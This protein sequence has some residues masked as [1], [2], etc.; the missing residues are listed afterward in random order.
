MWSLDHL[1]VSVPS[2]GLYKTKPP[3]PRVIKTLIQVPRQGQE[4]RTKNKKTIVVGENEILTREIQ[5]HMKPWVDIIRENA[6][7]LGGHRDHVSACLCHMLYCIETST[8]YNLAFFIL[9][10]MEK[11]RF[12]LKELL[13]YGM[14]LTSSSSTTQNH[15]SSSHLLDHIVDENDD[16]S[17]HSNSS[18]PSQQV[19]SLS[20]VASRV[21]QNPSHESHELNI[22]LSK[23]ITLQTQQQNAHQDGLRLIG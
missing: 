3:S 8:P 18:S 1:S 10:R 21:R 5:T 23:T 12:K 22:F 16:E 19:S 14:L 11:T 20:N 4:T 2:R 13:P 17:F 6:I 9:K 15:P 7:C